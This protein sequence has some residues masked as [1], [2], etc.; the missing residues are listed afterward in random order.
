MAEHVTKYFVNGETQSTSDHKLTPK[1]LLENAGFAP[2]SEYKLVREDGHKELT[3][4]N[5]EESIYEGERFT[6]TSI[7]PTPTS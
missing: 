5:K 1:Q 4:H 2:H 7:A 3:D 6:A